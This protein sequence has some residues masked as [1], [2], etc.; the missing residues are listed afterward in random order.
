V[1]P[2]ALPTKAAAAPPNDALARMLWSGSELDEAWAQRDP[3]NKA[4]CVLTGAAERLGGLSMICWDLE[5]AQIAKGASR[6]EDGPTSIY[7]FLARTLADL[8]RGL[9]QAHRLYWDDV[10]A[11]ENAA[12]RRSRRTAA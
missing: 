7:S 8:S 12:A 4:V 2:I 11:K 9:S 10:N 5:F 1:A 6:A 3:T